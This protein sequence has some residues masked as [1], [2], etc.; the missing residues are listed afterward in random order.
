MRDLF[1]APS[2]Q[3]AVLRASRCIHLFECAYLYHMRTLIVYAI[4]RAWRCIRLHLMQKYTWN[5]CASTCIDTYTYISVPAYT[6]IHIHTYAHMKTR[7]NVHATAN[8]IE[9]H[10]EYVCIHMYRYVYI[11]ECTHIYVCTHTYI[12]R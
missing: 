5:V 2:I 4:L 6:C 8:Y 12:C 7:I 10:L 9:I 11:Y 1:F 3:T